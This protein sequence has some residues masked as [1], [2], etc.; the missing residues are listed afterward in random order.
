VTNDAPI[1]HD[2][3]AGESFGG[4][5]LLERISTG[6]AG[7]LYRGLDEAQDDEVA[8]RIIRP[9]I[10]GSDENP[11]AFIAG[12]VAAA[13]LEHP[14]LVPVRKIG[15]DEPRD[16]YYM[17]SELVPGETLGELTQR[18]GRLEPLDVVRAG[19]QI[20]DALAVAHREGVFHDVLHPHQLI[21]TPV[22]DV[23]VTDFGLRRRSNEEAA[24]Y[25]QRALPHMAPEG[26][27]GGA[28]SAKIDLYALGSSLHYAATGELPSSGRPPA[29]VILAKITEKPPPIR[30]TVPTAPVALDTVLLRLLS[31][32]PEL[33]Y[34]NADEVGDELRAI[35]T[36]L[37]PANAWCAI[38]CRPGVGSF[39]TCA[40]CGGDL[41]PALRLDTR[42]VGA[43]PRG[44]HRAAVT[45]DA[46]D[47]ITGTEGSGEATTMA[48]FPDDDLAAD[49]GLR[50]CDRRTVDGVERPVIGEVA[51]L[52]ELG[53]GGMGVVYL[54]M[55]MTLRRRVAV[56][57][58]PTGH[59]RVNEQ[60]RYAE[61]FMREAR[62]AARLNSPHVVGVH[63]FGNDLTSQLSYIVMPFVD[64]P[65]ARG[66]ARGRSA[67]GGVPEAEAL[68]VCIAT[69]TGLAHA[70]EHGIVHRDVKP[71]NILIP[72]APDGSLYL[73]RAMLADLG[74][75]RIGEQDSSL[76]ATGQ[77]M[78]TPGFMSPEQIGDASAVDHRTDVFSLGASLYALLTG[79]S[80][81]KTTGNW[82]M[83]T[84]SGG[85]PKLAQV[86]PDVGPETSHLIARC[87]RFEPSERFGS[88]A[89]LRDAMQRAHA[90]L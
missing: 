25:M 77:G 54:G 4:F 52:N 18:H 23:K 47:A 13:Q 84:M 66:W 17:V 61:R 3:L 7:A 14:G 83:N 42:P 28:A 35:L 32:K 6:G 49:L 64:G 31:S 30:A 5:V 46:R 40:I 50:L 62:L 24:Q 65:T 36:S 39:S 9:E 85:Y 88:A 89:E 43:P 80:P 10:A 67:G 69:A 38:C 48:D 57:V 26:L 71:E 8:V 76:T 53:R 74:L 2:T 33:R 90:L 15:Y 21:V 19:I 60:R 82:V 58:L 81:F 45:R 78:G 20:C 73:D 11:R 75:G 86:R 79:S 63:T 1:D 34:A 27:T 12:A 44:G 87:L 29:E 37:G 22:G 68:T 59:R 56:K 41:G 16:F 55:D 72:R 70:H 51:L